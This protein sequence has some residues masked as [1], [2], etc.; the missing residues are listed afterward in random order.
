MTVARAGS[1]RERATAAM[2]AAFAACSLVSVRADPATEQRPATGGT[3]WV[4]VSQDRPT[5]ATT[6]TSSGAQSPAIRPRRFF[7]RRA[8]GR[9][10]GRGRGRAGAGRAAGRALVTAPTVAPPR[11]CAMTEHLLPGIV[12][13]RIET[14][15]LTQQVLHREDVDP[16]GGGEAV[17]LVHGNV[18]SALFWQ[19]PLQ[20]LD[21]ARRALAVDLRG[22]GD[23][24]TPRWTPPVGSVTGP[25]TWT[26]WSPPWGWSG[27]TWWAGAWAAASSCSSCSTTPSGSPR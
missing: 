8:A 15:R 5:T 6:T 1:P 25:T 4:S 27:C 10:A 26:R 22:F 19:Q 3:P 23:T 13:S 7:R 20:A 17:L 12:A 11:L 14:G 21:P 9:A 18:S 24:D 2:V 16:R